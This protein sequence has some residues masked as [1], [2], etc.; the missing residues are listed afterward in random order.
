[1][2]ASA[3]GACRRACTVHPVCY[4]T[5]TQ[6]PSCYRLEARSEN[7]WDE[8]FL[9]VVWRKFHVC[10]SNERVQEVRACSC[11]VRN[12][13]SKSCSKCSKLSFCSGWLLHY[14]CS[15]S[16][17]DPAARINHRNVKTLY[18]LQFNYQFLSCYNAVLTLWFGLGTKSLRSAS[19]SRIFHIWIS[20]LVPRTQ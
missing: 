16:R 13:N 10:R 8:T 15:I 5:A 12:L 19:E 2:R 1:M 6:F 7:S 17:V 9:S 20:V 14:V 11:D 18:F 4:Y 3:A